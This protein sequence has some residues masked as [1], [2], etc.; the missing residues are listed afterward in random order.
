MPREISTSA[1][2]RRPVTRARGKTTCKGHDPVTQYIDNE[3]RVLFVSDG[4][5]D[6]KTWATYRRRP[7]GSLQRVK[8]SR[9]K[10]RLTRE[11]AQA[12]LDRFA[13]RNDLRPAMGGEKPAAKKKPEASAWRCIGCGAVKWA[14]EPGDCKA[15]NDCSSWALCWRYCTRCGEK[16]CPSDE[17]CP[18]CKNPEFSLDPVLQTQLRKENPTMGRPRGSGTKTKKRKKVTVQLL[19]RI[20]QK[21]FRTHSNQSQLDFPI[22]LLF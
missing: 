8:S 17:R 13:R 9:L 5:S 16:Y 11:A 1:E 21:H 3:G 22:D 10:L 6:A 4:I 18:K 2:D 20:L 12:D 14:V 19:K 15:C 7:S